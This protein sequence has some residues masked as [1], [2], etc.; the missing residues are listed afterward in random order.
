MSSLEKQIRQAVAEALG[1]NDKKKKKDKPV[2]VE[3]ELDL[4]A[5]ET[6]K[7]K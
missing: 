1:L 7:K 3:E 2:E 4:E 6:G 5:L